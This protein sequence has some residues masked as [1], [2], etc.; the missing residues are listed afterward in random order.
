MMKHD[1]THL[2]EFFEKVKNIGFIERLFAWKAVLSLSYDAYE[3][4]KSV[5]KKLEAVNGELNKASSKIEKQEINQDHF[6]EIRA[7]LEAEKKV[8]EQKKEDLTNQIKEL[9]KEV[10][11]FRKVEKKNQEEQKG[12]MEEYATLIKQANDD[13]IRIQQEGEDEIKKQFARMKETW[14]AHQDNVQSIVKKV[15]SRYD[16]EYVEKVPFKGNPDNTIKICDEHIIFDAK[17]PAGDD[18]SNFSNYVKTQAEAAKKYAK[19]KSVKKDIFLVIPTNTA[20]V[21]NQTYY[22]LVDYSVHVVTPNAIEP[23]ILSLQKI[24][25]YEFAEKLSPED[26]EQICRIIGKFA[27]ATKRRIQVDHF[28]AQ[29]AMDILTKCYELPKEILDGAVEA[30]KS[31]MLN[32]PQERRAKQISLEDLRKDNKRLKK[33]AEAKDIDTKADLKIIESVPLYK[34][35]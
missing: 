10:S 5:D 3:E 26:R 28:F 15:C 14:Q 35:E 13:R 24:E 16:I 21:I 22:N 34:D 4:F 19:E 27:H 2:H 17:S 18:L 20:D 29:E 6:K 12:K 33:E 7:T 30:E 32:P 1:F 8:L 9:E 31:G 11:G 25:D 23:I